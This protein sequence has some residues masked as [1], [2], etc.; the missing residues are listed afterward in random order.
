MVFGS[1]CVMP[2]CVSEGNVQCSGGGSCDCLGGS[3]RGEI[4]RYIWLSVARKSVK[5]VWRGVCR[6]LEDIF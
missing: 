3:L 2:V 4:R 5:D 6:S 1:D